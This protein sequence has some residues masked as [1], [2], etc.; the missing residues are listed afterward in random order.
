MNDRCHALGRCVCGGLACLAVTTALDEAFGLP[1]TPKREFVI[2][3]QPLMAP[4]EK[5]R[6]ES[7]AFAGLD[8]RRATWVNSSGS[9]A[10]HLMVTYVSS[11]VLTLHH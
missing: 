5:T 3:G 2:A 9:I 11:G 1:K 8:G 4:K 6:E 10:N 7:E